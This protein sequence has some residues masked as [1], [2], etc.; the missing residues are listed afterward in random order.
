MTVGLVH[1]LPPGLGGSVL[2]PGLR[3]VILIERSLARRQR[4]AAL[5]HE[6]AHLERGGGA[7]Y[8]GAPP[9]WDA[10]VARDELACD[11]EVARAQVP[12]AELLA[13]CRRR[14]EMGESTRPHDV[15]DEFD[16]AE[17]VA[18][19]SLRLLPA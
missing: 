5:G 11:R 7:D 14:A 1:W 19:L 12:A 15:A 18:S 2:V 4:K 8:T 13:F 6:L 9:G 16:V 10:V 3:P 17:W